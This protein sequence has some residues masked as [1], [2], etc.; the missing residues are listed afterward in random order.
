MFSQSLQPRLSSEQ[1]SFLVIFTPQV[2]IDIALLALLISSCLIRRPRH[3]PKAIPFKT[4]F[5]SLLGNIISTSLD[6][7]SIWRDGLHSYAAVVVGDICSYLPTFLIANV[8][9]RLTYAYNAQRHNRRIKPHL[10]SNVHGSILL[11]LFVLSFVSTIT[12]IIVTF[13]RNDL[14]ESSIE[15]AND[16]IAFAWEIL[17]L[18]SSVEV[19]LEI[20]II[21]WRPKD[22]GLSS[23]GIIS[24]I[25]GSFFFFFWNLFNLV[26]G[27]QAQNLHCRYD[28]YPW[29]LS[30]F[31]QFLPIANAIGLTG[32]YTGIIYCCM[33]WHKPGT[34]G[35]R[36]PVTEDE[37][38]HVLTASEESLR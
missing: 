36:K 38:T 8:L 20:F 2:A 13:T 34:R 12:S 29:G 22:L 5:V 7:V 27:I 10:L 4:L 17:F 37:T 35:P 11:I 21:T 6:A 16:K 31:C 19:M 33:Q 9:Y 15:I 3:D 32:S 18:I 1:S 23:K 26:P 24:L 14:S 28:Y 30:A 25:L